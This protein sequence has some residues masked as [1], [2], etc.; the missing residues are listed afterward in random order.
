[1]TTYIVHGGNAQHSNPQNDA[2]FSEILKRTKLHDIKILLV[3]F[4]GKPDRDE[5]NKQIDS[6]QFEKNKGNKNITLQVASKEKFIEQISWADVIYFGGGTTVKLIEELKH[7]PNIAS[8]FETKVVA[9]ES[10]GANI[11]STLCY[12]KSGGGVIEGLGILPIFV[13]P[14]HEKSDVNFSIP[15]NLQKLFLSNYQ[16]KVFEV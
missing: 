4:A 8:R 5:L 15:D 2:F 10:A 3:H 14:H 16:Y 13:Y 1:M 7:F 9:G 6:S 12:S 11:L